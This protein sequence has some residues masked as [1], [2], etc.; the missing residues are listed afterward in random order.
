MKDPLIALDAI[1]PILAS[2]IVTNALPGAPAVVGSSSLLRRSPRPAPRRI[3]ADVERWTA[4]RC[5][6][7][8]HAAL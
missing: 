4:T 8:A 7:A 1:S 3:V 2:T 6:G 5:P